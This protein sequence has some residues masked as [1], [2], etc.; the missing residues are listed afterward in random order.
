MPRLSRVA[1][2]LGVPVYSGGGFDG[3]K[4]KRA[5]A[6]RAL[7]RSVPTV[8]LHIGDRDDF[9]D[10]IYV[11]AAEDSVAWAANG[12]VFPLDTDVEPGDLPDLLDCE[13]PGSGSCASR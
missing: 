13:D 7:G 6:D 10:R 2:H 4:G 12:M 9:G 8:V 5:F 3:L 1:N 11:A